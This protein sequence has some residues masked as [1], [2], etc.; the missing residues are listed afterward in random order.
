MLN[1]TR[2]HSHYVFRHG[3]PTLTGGRRGTGLAG[4]VPGFAHVIGAAAHLLGHVE[5][6]LVLAGVVEVAVAH[7]LS[8]ICET[9]TRMSSRSCDSVLIARR[10]ALTHAVVS[11]VHLHVLGWTDAGVVSQRVVAGSWT[12]DADV[13]R[14]FINI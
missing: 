11:S 5:G 6:E 9:E 7:A 1:A 14:T 10:A 12:A 13:R 4:S 2:I 3:S 8:H